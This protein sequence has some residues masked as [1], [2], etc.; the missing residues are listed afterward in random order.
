VVAFEP[1]LNARRVLQ[2]HIQLNALTERVQVI[3]AAVGAAYGDEI[4]FAAG[5]DGMSRLGAPNQAIADRVSAVTVPVVTL[6]GFCEAEKLVPDWL[7][8]DIEGFEIAA[9]LGAR[10]LIRSRRGLMGIIVE[11]HPNVWASANTTRSLAEEI[12]AEL[13]LHPVALTGQRDPL[14]EHGLVYLSEQ[15]PSLNTSNDI[16]T[17]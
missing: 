2:K 16:A 7:L 11:M 3:P 6:D 14:S 10:E 12:L 5:T 17:R 9:L 4:L 13:Q 8:I 1:N 15:G